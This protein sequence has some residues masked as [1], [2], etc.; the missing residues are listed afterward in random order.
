MTSLNED[1]NQENSQ[2]INS[3]DLAQDESINESN[4]KH[5]NEIKCCCYKLSNDSDEQK[6][7]GHYPALQTL[8]RQSL[9]PLCSQVVTSMYLI[10]D[11]FWVSHTIGADGLTATGAVSL[12]E[13][14]NNA[15]G[16]YL[17]S[18]VSAR[19]SYLFG[20]KKNEE[21]AQVFVDIIRISWIFS[22]IL[23]IIM[24]NICK[25]LTKWFGAD[26]HIQN[27]G[28][29]YLIPVTGLTVF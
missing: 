29:Q 14:I 18:C 15:F 23:P 3:A 16:L 25:P 2:S 7:L 5:E 8:L 4:D 9:G 24:L 22:V 28:F 12:L 27:M 11:S 13:A 19:I 10:V 1:S 26:E 20:Q 21:C 17:L 6:R